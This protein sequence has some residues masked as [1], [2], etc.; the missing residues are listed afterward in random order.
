MSGPLIQRPPHVYFAVVLICNLVSVRDHTE[1][2]R[3]SFF[4]FSKTPRLLSF[5]N[6]KLPQNC[7]A[8]VHFYKH[9]HLLAGLCN[10]YWSP[11]FWSEVVIGQV[12]YRG[13][14]ETHRGGRNWVAGQDLDEDPCLEPQIMISDSLNCHVFY[15]ERFIHIWLKYFEGS[16]LALLL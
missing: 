3:S 7:Q 10:Q 5:E 11:V 16:L 13:T 1:F 4:L 15:V 14:I 6:L 8:D 2:L 12:L 9:V